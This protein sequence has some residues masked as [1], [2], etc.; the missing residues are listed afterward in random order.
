MFTLALLVT[1]KNWQQSKCPPIKQIETFL[2]TMKYHSAIKRNKLLIHTTT[3]MDLNKI[4]L[5]K[6]KKANLKRLHTV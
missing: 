2:S 4:M 3:W 5:S 6:K 1:A